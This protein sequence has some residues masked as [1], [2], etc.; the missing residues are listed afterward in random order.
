MILPSSSR[1]ADLSRA[2]KIISRSRL[3]KGNG[4]YIPAHSVSRGRS[5][6]EVC[7]NK[8]SQTRSGFTPKKGA[9]RAAIHETG[10]FRSAAIAGPA[11][12]RTPEL[13]EKIKELVRLAQEQGQ[14][15]Y[16]DINETA[17]GKRG[18]A[19]KTGRNFFQAAR[20]GN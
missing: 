10:K 18:D 7:Q 12:V 14:L 17:A 13:A 3:T 16:N 1:R 2:G 6:V 15:T 5:V 9:R 8:G 20:A 19:G 4:F 11:S